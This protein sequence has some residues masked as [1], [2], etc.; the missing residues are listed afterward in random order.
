MA[1][2]IEEE[3]NEPMTPEEETA[4][5]VISE[6]EA[7]EEE[8]IVLSKAE[9]DE[10]KA[11]LAEA[12]SKEQENLENW[13]RERASFSNYMKSEEQR[14]E[15][16]SRGFKMDFIKKMLPILD[17]LNLAFEH[18]G[19]EGTELI[20]RKFNAALE[21]Q[22]VEKIEAE[23]GME[24]DAKLHMAVSNEPNDEFES[25]QIIAVLQNGYKMGDHVIREA[26]VRVA[27]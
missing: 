3:S 10:L 17:D 13:Q 4:E 8:I 25:G 23:S 18:T 24:F 26:I 2:K 11:Q 5:T 19:D 6:E 16:T 22:G 7:A 15:I 9:L 20:I 12:Q 14:R 21:T 1:K 27:A